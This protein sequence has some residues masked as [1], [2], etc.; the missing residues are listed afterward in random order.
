MLRIAG[1][2][3]E[4]WLGSY[5]SRRLLRKLLRTRVGAQNSLHV[6][7]KEKHSG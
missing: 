6:T 1:R 7:F 4:T 3:A 2:T 5:P